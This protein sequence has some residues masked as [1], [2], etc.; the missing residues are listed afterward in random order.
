MS[1]D[2]VTNLPDKRITFDLDAEEREDAPEVFVANVNGRAISMQDPEELDWKDLLD[3][4]QPVDFIKYAVA[5]EDRQYIFAQKIKSWKLNRLMERYMDHYGL[6]EKL[7][8]AD[9]RQKFG[10]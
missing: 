6:K 10:Y 2:N 8:E 3:I 7:A 1:D 9:R 5:E 4:T